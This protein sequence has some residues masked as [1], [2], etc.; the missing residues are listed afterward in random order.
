MA[1]MVTGTAKTTGVRYLHHKESKCR[2]SDVS[3]TETPRILPTDPLLGAGG[4]WIPGEEP[5]NGV[6]EARQRNTVKY[7]RDGWG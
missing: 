1:D 7:S 5:L 3:A 4:P 6:W 2:M